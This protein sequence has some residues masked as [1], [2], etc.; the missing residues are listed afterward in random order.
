MCV[1]LAVGKTEP[2]NGHFSIGQGAQS[3]ALFVTPS[4]RETA[5]TAG[6]GRLTI[7]HRQDG[8]GHTGHGLAGEQ[9]TAQQRL[10]VGVRR[11]D[12]RR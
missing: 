2:V 10:V 6:V 3:D 4:L 9:T 5:R 12:Q 1:D 7:G 8:D 11:H